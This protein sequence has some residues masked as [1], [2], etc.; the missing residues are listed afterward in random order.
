MSIF[1]FNADSAPRLMNLARVIGICTL[2]SATS[3]SAL[4]TTAAAVNSSNSASISA[5]GAFAG[6]SL[7]GWSER[8][9]E[10]NTEYELVTDA[11]TNTQ[12]LKGHTNKQASI[13]YREQTIDL[14]ETPVVNWSWKVD[15]TFADIDE[16][17][18][19]GDD[20]PAR[21]YVVAKTGFLPWETLAINYVWSSQ[22]PVGDS[23]HNPFTD[24][25]KMV[26]VES[27]SANVGTWMSHT[28]NVAQ[29]FKTFFNTDI[30]EIDGFAVMVDGDNSQQEAVAWFG[31]IQF[32]PEPQS[33][34]TVE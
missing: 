4:A 34:V 1:L 25:A 27:G 2:F 7:E 16:K 29:D 30:D 11:Q 18:K 14:L 13:L 3:V 19:S 24:K 33:E 9:F 28:R 32:S 10:G 15:R 20:F 8:S 23:W 5:V 12:V 17:A 21:L 22:L 6:G 31:E 26:V